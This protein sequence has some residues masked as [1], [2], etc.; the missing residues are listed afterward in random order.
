[1]AREIVWRKA[2][3][4]DIRGFA[5]EEELSREETDRVN[6]SAGLFAEKMRE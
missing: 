3:K 2:F 1:V 6:V 5:K 4:I